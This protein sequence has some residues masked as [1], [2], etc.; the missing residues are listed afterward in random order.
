MDSDVAART[1]KTGI[2][3]LPPLLAGLFSPAR[4]IESIRLLQDV[5]AGAGAAGRNRPAVHRVTL[6]Y[7]PHGAPRTGDLYRSGK[8]VAGLVLMPGASPQGKDDPRLVAFAE[9]LA[10]A[11]FEVLVPDLPGLR[12]LRVSAD[13]ADLVADALSALSQHRAA[14]GNATMGLIAICYSTG[15]AM[16]ALLEE[17]ARGTAQFMLSIGGFYDLEAVIAFF[18]TGCY[19]N[20]ADGLLRHRPPDE[21]GKWIFAISNV[22]ALEDPK[23]RERLDAMARRRLDDSEAELCDLAAGLGEEGRRVYALLENRDPDRVPALMDALPQRIKAEIARLDLKRRDFSGLDMRFILMHGND[24]AVIPETES[25]ALAGALPAADL[26][27]LHSMQHVDPGPAG[28]A[29]KL[30]LLAAMQG[31]LRERDRVR[32]PNAAA[33]KSPLQV[34]TNPCG[35]A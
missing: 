28:I 1:G 11:R 27:I 13:D 7:A 29:D 15:P 9:A 5:Q 32:P 16:L 31:F 12:S 24:D 2:A 17:R 8:P 26:Y 21:Y 3:L 14:G 6:D 33:G 30:K 10:R 25:M 18:T 19:R 34:P 4:L 35:A 20:P 23:D 22:A